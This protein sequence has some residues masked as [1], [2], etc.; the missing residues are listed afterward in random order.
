[1]PELGFKQVRVN[2]LNVRRNFDKPHLG[3]EPLE[4]AIEAGV[5]VDGWVELNFNGL[6]SEGS[7]ILLEVPVKVEFELPAETGVPSVGPVD[8]SA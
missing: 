2:R 4:V 5:C 7:K 1:M 6:V 8:C 3:K